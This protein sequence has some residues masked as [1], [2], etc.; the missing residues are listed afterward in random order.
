MSSPK[1]DIT[2]YAPTLVNSMMTGDYYVAGRDQVKEVVSM[3]S[4]D[5]F[6][7]MG[8]EVDVRENVVFIGGQRS[9]YDS[10][11]YTTDITTNE[12]LTLDS[13]RNITQSVYDG[14]H[15]IQFNAAHFTEAEAAEYVIY[16]KQLA[17]VIES[18][19]GLCVRVLV[20]VQN[21]MA[22]NTTAREGLC[23]NPCSSSRQSNL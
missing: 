17:H 18:G 12:Q 20:R 22:K 7:D 4:G 14:R 3:T 5:S 9:I 10:S 6:Y 19:N 21:E 13:A 16:A 8:H 23:A 15:H 1:N 11:A 2:K